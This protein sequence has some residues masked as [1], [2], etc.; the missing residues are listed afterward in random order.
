MRWIGRLGCEAI[1]ARARFTGCLFGQQSRREQAE[2]VYASANRRAC[3]QERHRRRLKF[4]R[5]HKSNEH[6][7]RRFLS[8]GPA[9][10]SQPLAAQ[11]GRAHK[12]CSG[13]LCIQTTND[14]VRAAAVDACQ[15]ASSAGRRITAARASCFSAGNKPRKKLQMKISRFIRGPKKC[16]WGRSNKLVVQF[17]KAD[18]NVFHLQPPIEVDLLPLKHSNC[19]GFLCCWQGPQFPLPNR[20]GVQNGTATAYS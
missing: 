10:P 9:G 15:T 18:T 14:G 20:F 13:A 5:R 17:G 19:F 1:R 3:R 2:R 7:Q 11:G 6:H 12:G 16:R 4:R 8:A